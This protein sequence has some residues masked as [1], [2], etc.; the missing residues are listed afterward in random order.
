MGSVNKVIL[1]GESGP[2]PRGAN[3]SYWRKSLQSRIATSETWKDKDTGE[4]RERTEWQG[5][6]QYA[7]CRAERIRPELTYRGLR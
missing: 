6:A 7:R 2:R 4:R 1:I 5:Q 3:V